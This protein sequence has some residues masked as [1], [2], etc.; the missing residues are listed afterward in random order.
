METVKRTRKG[1]WSRVYPVGR[2]LRSGFTVVSSIYYGAL[3]LTVYRL[4]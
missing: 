1:D 3:D 2:V 4:V